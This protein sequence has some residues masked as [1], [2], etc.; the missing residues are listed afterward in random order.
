MQPFRICECFL[1]ART[2]EMYCVDPSSGARA[3]SSGPR[4]IDDDQKHA[5]A[6]AANNEPADVPRGLHVRVTSTSDLALEASACAFVCNISIHYACRV[7]VTGRLHLK[8]SSSTRYDGLPAAGG[9][10]RAWCELQVDTCSD[11]AANTGPR[12]LRRV[13]SSLY[14]RCDNTCI[15]PVIRRPVHDAIDQSSV[16]YFY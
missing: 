5:P 2:R 12:L 1:S 3:A 14:G 16:L 11:N 8:S 9:V 7:K 4:V 13:I 15:L 10:P 6:A